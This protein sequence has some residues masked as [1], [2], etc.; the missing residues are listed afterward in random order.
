MIESSRVVA[1][2]FTVRLD[3]QLDVF[4]HQL[5][6]TDDC[7]VRAKGAETVRVQRITNKPDE[8]GRLPVASPTHGERVSAACV[9]RGCETRRD[10]SQI[11]SIA[12]TVDSGA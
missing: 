6:H 3:L 8:A 12:V 9:D 5:L 11:T 1:V 7:V 4:T 2:P 10:T